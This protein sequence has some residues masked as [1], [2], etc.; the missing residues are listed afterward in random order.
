MKSL[1]ILGK[2]FS[3]P[4][5]YGIV[6]I[7][8]DI[9]YHKERSKIMRKKIT[10]FFLC[11]C[12]AATLFGCGA[13]TDAEK[14]V[15]L[16][17]YKKLEVE[18]DKSYEITDD[19]V[20]ENIEGFFLSEPIYTENTEKTVVEEGDVANIDYEGKKDGEAFEGGTAEGYNLEI[21]SGT[22]IDGFESGLVGKK[23][24]EEVDLNLTFPED[25]STEDLAGKEVVFHVK[26]NSIQDKTYPTYDTLTDEYVAENYGTYYGV[27]TVDE[28]KKYVE[29]F[30]NDSHDNAVGEALTEKLKEV[31]KVSDIPDDLLKERTEEL[32]SYYKGLA[33]AQDMEFADF[34]TNNYGM[35]EDDFN[36][37]IDELMPDY[38]TSDLVWEAVAAKE[39]IK[40]EGSDYKKFISD[41]MKNLSFDTED[42][43]YEVYPETMVK[44]MYVEQEAKEKLVKTTKVKYVD[45][46]DETTED[47]STTEDS[48]DAAEES[49]A[50]DEVVDDKIDTTTGK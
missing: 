32:K 29:D 45:T 12:M 3:I 11:T 10:A 23:V 8:E 42:A 48:E 4:L 40:A 31:S 41:M 17:D 36:E 49:T 33:K 47:A 21:G 7:Y 28:L 16:G 35:T 14:L 46:T 9:K 5:K 50:D 18:L 2:I 43:L 13:K 27:S 25:Y 44:R 22:F 38:I 6:Y 20:K 30:L 1:L 24:G 34:L 19:S 39:G 37:Q 15:E 26:I